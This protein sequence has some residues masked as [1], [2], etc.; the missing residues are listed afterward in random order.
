M[1]KPSPFL[2]A[3]WRHLLMMNYATDPELLKPYLPQGTEIDFFNGET[4]VSVVG[5]VFLNTR[6]K[7]L[8]I[9]FHQNFEELNLRFY[10]RRYEGRELRRGV[11]FIKEVVPRWA[12]A[13]VARWVYNENYISLPMD[14]AIPSATES[15]AR[16]EYRWR[17]GARW[18]RVGAAI[19]GDLQPLP[20]GSREEFIAEH[21]WGYTAQR[22]GGT[23]EYRVDHEPWRMW[24]VRDPYLDAD[25]TALYGERFSPV[26]AKPPVSAFIAEGS[27][28]SVHS[29]VRVK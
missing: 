19:G 7:G 24:P 9:P 17:I 8:A 14:R 23:L 26:L 15:G 13:T 18:H 1:S 25:V 6:L 4:Y 29:G 21:Y 28:V 20:P 10:V 22:D 2:T 3:E 5:F 16:V 27:P 12:V 11:V